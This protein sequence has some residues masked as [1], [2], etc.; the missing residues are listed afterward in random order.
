MSSAY[1]DREGLKGKLANAWAMYDRVK[2]ELMATRTKLSSA[3]DDREGLKGKLAN[4]WAKY[5]ELKLRWDFVTRLLN[6]LNKV[7]C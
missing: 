4:A 1:D 6:S 5:D 7:V 2:A 3:Y